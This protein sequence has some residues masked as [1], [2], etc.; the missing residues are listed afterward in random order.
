MKANLLGILKLICFILLIPFLAAL[1]SSFYTETTRGSW[2]TS[3]WFIYGPMLFVAIY[4]F[5]YNFKEAYDFGQNVVT[6]LLG[7]AKSIATVG[8]LI[9]PIYA[10]AFAIAFL[11]LRTLGMLEKYE[12]VAIMALSF[13]WSMHVVLTAQQLN[14][15]DKTVV[16]GGYFLSFSLALVFH[17]IIGGLLLAMAIPEFSFV[18][19][20]KD[21]FYQTV[22]NYHGIYKLLFVP[23]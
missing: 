19:F 2:E 8:A 18:Q 6:K 9:I 21:T 20:I 22:D 15:G 4:L 5:I 11:I 1:L 23:S 7:F 16:R 3:Q 17:V 12:S 14:E 10:L 13:L